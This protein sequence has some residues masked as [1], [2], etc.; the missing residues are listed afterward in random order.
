MTRVEESAMC[1]TLMFLPAKNRLET[2]FE[3][4]QRYGEEIGL[5]VVLVGNDQEKETEGENRARITNG[6][7]SGMVLVSDNYSLEDKSG[8]GDAKLSRERAK[9]VLMNKDVN[10]M[11]DFGRSARPV[12][13]YREYND[14]GDGAENCFVLDTDKYLYVSVVNYKDSPIAGRILLERL[15][16]SVADFASVKE[17][18]SGDDVQVGKDGLSYAVPG[19]DAKIYRFLK[20]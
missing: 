1:V 4:R 5:A 11:A 2:F 10:E 7:V 8:R 18:W 17:L 6:A 20:K 13:G 15:G 14:Q 16:I 9:K 19:K 3:Y 12:F